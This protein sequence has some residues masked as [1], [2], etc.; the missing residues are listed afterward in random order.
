MDGWPEQFLSRL[1]AASPSVYNQWVWES[2]P[3]QVL[4]REGKALSD[5]REYLRSCLEVGV[6]QWGNVE[7]GKGAWKDVV[8]NR[9]R[10]LE[11]W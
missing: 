9:L 4:G 8:E 11:C 1:K 2:D 5:V 10:V 7:A 3:E 6:R